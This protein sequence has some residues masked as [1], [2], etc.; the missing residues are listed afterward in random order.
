MNSLII[1]GVFILCYLASQL[2]D[3]LFSANEFILARL[4]LAAIC[5]TILPLGIFLMLEYTTNF[6]IR[7]HA[8]LIFLGYFV[9]VSL[10]VSRAV[11]GERKEESD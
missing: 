10:A 7:D 6:R 11:Q 1:I 9:L 4:G 5:R 8:A 3:W 2:S